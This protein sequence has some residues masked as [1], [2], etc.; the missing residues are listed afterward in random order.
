MK[1]KVTHPRLTGGVSTVLVVV[2]NV[3]KK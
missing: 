2:R 1:T 3:M